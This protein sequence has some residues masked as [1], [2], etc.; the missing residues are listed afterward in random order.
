M[1][2][3]GLPLTLKGQ[4]IALKFPPVFVIVAPA[5]SVNVVELALKW[6]LTLLVI[7]V[8]FPLSPIVEVALVV[9][10]PELVRYPPA[11]I[12]KFEPVTVRLLAPVKLLI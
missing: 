3:L 2:L 1:I 12:A 6:L 10:V 7:E 11:P 9:M 8:G 4:E 5:T